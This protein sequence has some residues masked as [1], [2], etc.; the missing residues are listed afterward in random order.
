MSSAAVRTTCPYCGVGCGV[1]ATYAGAGSTT[2]AGDDSHP[3]NFGRLCSKGS[4]LGETL[5]FDGRLL[6]PEVGGRRVDWPTALDAVADGFA[7]V[8][9]DHGPDAVAF[10]VSGQLLTEDY[11]VAN[12]LIKGFLGTA[13]IDTNSRLCMASSVAGH[14]RAFGSDTVPG[15]YQDLEQADLVVLVGSNL[16]WCHPV[17]FQRLHAAKVVRPSLRI[18]CI[19]PRRTPTAEESDLHLPLAPGSD[20][21]LFNGLLRHLHETGKTDRTYVDRHTSGRE[22]AL[23]A[24]TAEPDPTVT[25]DLDPELVAQFYAW[26]ADSERVVTVYS[27]GVNQSSAGTDKVNA[28][29]NCHLLTGRIGRPGMGPF[30]VTGQPN[31]MG[32]R[33]VGALANQLAAHMDFS[34]TDLDRVRRFWRAPNL[35]TK[36]GLKAVDLFCAVE[37]GTIKALWIMATNPA[38]SLPDADRVQTALRR[39]E[40]VVV[41]D[42]VRATDTA[43]TAHVLLPALAW[44]EKDGTVTNSERLISRQRAFLPP[45]GEARPEWWILSEVARRLGF[46]EAF[47]YTSAADV[48]REHAALTGFENDGTRDLDL[49]GLLDVPYETMRPVQWPVRATP[50]IADAAPEG[51]RGLLGAAARRALARVRGVPEGDGR[52]TDG[53]FFGDGRYYTP[54]RKGRF[55]AVRARPPVEATD[56]KWPLR[57]NT[58]RVRDQWH[59]MTRTG[60]SPRLSAHAPEPVVDVHPADAQAAGLIDGGLA[61]LASRWGAAVLRVR[62]SDA[63]RRGELFAPMHWT[64]QLAARGRINGVV[65]PAV[66]PVSGQPELKHTPVKVAPWQARW[67]GFLLS[68]AP[69]APATSYWVRAAGDGHWRHEIADTTAPDDASRRLVE[70]LGIEGDRLDLHDRAGGTFRAAWV[71]DGRLNACLFLGATPMLPSRAWLAQL[72]AEA[73]LSP[74]DRAAL[75]AGRAPSGTFDSGPV[76]CACH[77]VSE[78]RIRAAIAAG[79]GS[80][81]AIGER[82][83][84]GT[85]CGS[86]LPEIRKLLA[87]R[88]AEMAMA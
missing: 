77:G 88:M 57:L 67:Y 82:T 9:R 20:V 84:A 56:T 44:G 14:R 54:D 11:Y 25:C 48:F 79:D 15:T 13:N 12:K 55:V 49:S 29:I 73:A 41:S 51:R 58:G 32:G 16:A 10:Y 3:A 43:D 36:P 7:R 66:D 23:L 78:T 30:S 61:T 76:I 71:L 70:S 83:Q 65:N 21:A 74:A 42:C 39:A 6:L 33:E 86:C 80:V 50:P 34:A 35:A 17:L 87:S 37:S 69:M 47:A 31:A 38:V 40:L 46:G 24:A 2:I 19:D 4:A 68:R 59:T 64:A 22:A 62:V 63:Q 52:A 72:F 27:Q 1:L 5:S 85:N 81:G 75:L 26:F 60:K 28:I 8:I 45:P 53:R 18:V